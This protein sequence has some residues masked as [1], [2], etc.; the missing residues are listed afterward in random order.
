MSKEF[1]EQDLI[2]ALNCTIDDLYTNMSNTD[3]SKTIVLC[4]ATAAIYKMAEHLGISIEPI[5]NKIA[6]I[7][8]DHN[9]EDK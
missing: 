1:T 3:F 9:E 4:G 5:S 6:C 2:N 7:L 8:E